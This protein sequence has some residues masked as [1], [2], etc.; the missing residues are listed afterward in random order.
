YVT[1]YIEQEFKEKLMQ[2]WP[3]KADNIY[4]IYK[5]IGFSFLRSSEEKFGTLRDEKDIQILSDAI[6]HGINVILSGDK[7]FL[8]SDLE[9]PMVM[10]V[11]MLYDYLNL[12]KDEHN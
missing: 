11:S 1:S 8:E 12:D 9:Y 4:K 7:D 5:N 6:F 10:S 3:Y 2:K